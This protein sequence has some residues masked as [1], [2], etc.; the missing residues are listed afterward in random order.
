MS[1]L[2]LL[3]EK[4]V[5]QLKELEAS[6]AEVRRKLEIVMEA[7]RLLEEEGFSEDSPSFAEKKAFL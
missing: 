4:Y 6:M 5:N 7:S 2:Q 1:S 3:T